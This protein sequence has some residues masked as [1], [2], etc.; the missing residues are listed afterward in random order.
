MLSEKLEVSEDAIRS[1]C[2]KW[3]IVQIDV[4]GSAIRSDFRDDSD[5]D[6]LIVYAEEA[7]PTLFDEGQMLEELEALFGRPVHFMTRRA[8]E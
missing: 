2:E 6:L 7:K 4:F 5:I 3:N 8:V 1:F